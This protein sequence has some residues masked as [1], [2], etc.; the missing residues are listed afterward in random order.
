MISRDELLTQAEAFELS[1]ANI[2][3]DYLFG[4]LI[5]GIFRESSLAATAVLK[6]GNALRKGYF[7]G[8]RF[9]EDL[10]FSTHRTP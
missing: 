5:A 3:R 10:D 7:P 9:S 2:Q 6:G 8:A 4:W 1:E